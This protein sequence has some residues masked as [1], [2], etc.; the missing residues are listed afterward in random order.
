MP[1][2]L[3]AARLFLCAYFIDRRDTSSY[4]PDTRKDFYKKEQQHDLRGTHQSF[5]LGGHEK[6]EI[7]SYIRS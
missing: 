7:E 3:M 6:R 2:G 1:G 4:N 5:R